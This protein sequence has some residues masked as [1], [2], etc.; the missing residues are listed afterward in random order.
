MLLFYLS[1]LENPEDEDEFTKLY[2]TYNKAMF[3]VAYSYLKNYHN[4]EDALQVAFVG[5]AKCFDM[6]RDLDEEKLKIYL[7][8]CV[9]NASISI[10]RSN[11]LPQ[12]NPVTLDD[13]ISPSQD[14]SVDEGVE[15]KEMLKEIFDFIKALDE[16][17]RDVLTLYY[18]HQLNFREIASS[19]SLPVSTVKDRFYKGKEL[20]AKKFKEHRK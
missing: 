13:K 1:I 11:N 2:N 4:S 18:I 9:K 8:K 7:F 6:V 19:L 17:H 14:S 15:K 16:K 12:N 10:L 20:I 5:I 3:K